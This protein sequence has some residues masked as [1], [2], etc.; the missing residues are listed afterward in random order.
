[1]TSV[2]EN[3]K[4]KICKKGI[5]GRS[6]KLFCSVRCKNY[7]HTNLRRVTLKASE[8][9]DGI[10][11][12]NRSILLE[13]MGKNLT[14]KKVPRFILEEKKFRFNYL[15]HYH[16]NKNGKMYHWIYDFAWMSFS[17]DEVLIVRKGH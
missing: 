5:V 16:V 15:T 17:N 11:H 7:Y 2:L 9:I 4:C 13:V 6:D 10:L 14:Q 8:G 3:M 12:R 1:M